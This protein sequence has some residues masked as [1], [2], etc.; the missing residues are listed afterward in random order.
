MTTP[1]FIHICEESQGPG[2]YKSFHQTTGTVVTS[3]SQGHTE[4]S[5]HT[6][7]HVTVNEQSPISLTAC[8]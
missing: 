7:A 3:S 1:A 6:P 4:S 2:A 5:V 8:F